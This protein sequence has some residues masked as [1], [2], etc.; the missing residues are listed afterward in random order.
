MEKHKL[1]E[2]LR[3]VFELEKQRRIEKNV[4]DYMADEYKKAENNVREGKKRYSLNKTGVFMRIAFLLLPGI[5][6]LIAV[7]GGVSSNQLA[8]GDFGCCFAMVVTVL[9]FYFF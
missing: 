2:Y 4:M 7:V 6:C 3:D 8:V 9:F 1:I 5:S